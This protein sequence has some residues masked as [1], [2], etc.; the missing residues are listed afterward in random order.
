KANLKALIF[1]CTFL[2]SGS[3]KFETFQ[4]LITPS[5]NFTI[6]CFVGYRRSRKRN[7]DPR[8]T[9]SDNF[10]CCTSSVGIYCLEFFSVFMVC[11]KEYVFYIVVIIAHTNVELI[12]IDIDTNQGKN[13][14][15]DQK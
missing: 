10:V 6:Q 12:R 2:G 13:V 15:F 11:E 7:V 8:S 4:L 3:E 5:K 1:V 14:F 9:D